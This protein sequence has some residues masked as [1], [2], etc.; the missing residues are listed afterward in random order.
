TLFVVVHAIDASLPERRA[1]RPADAGGGTR[2]HQELARGTDGVGRKLRRPRVALMR[3]V[4]S[5]IVVGGGI[6][7]LVAAT[8]LARRGV[9]V[10]VFEKKPHVTDDGGIGMGLQGNALKALATIGVAQP[11]M[12]AGISAENLCYYTP[13]GELAMKMPT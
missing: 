12:A 3:A 2:L 7:G 4:G 5:A 10:T 6:A 9:R 8:A 1:V 13:A 11:T